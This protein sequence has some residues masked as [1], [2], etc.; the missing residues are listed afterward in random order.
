MGS[1]LG[2]RSISELEEIIRGSGRK[3]PD[4]R[5][6]MVT[7]AFAEML[8]RYL[9]ATYSEDSGTIP[10]TTFDI[11]TNGLVE[12]SRCSLIVSEHMNAKEG[13]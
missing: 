4:D 5:L 8:R 6:P 12:I 13:L 7:A 3:C 2:G 1:T 10:R 9:V 11:L